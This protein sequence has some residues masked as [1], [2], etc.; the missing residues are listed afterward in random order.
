[1][2]LIA[3]EIA[4]RVAQ[5]IDLA[6]LFEPIGSPVRPSPLISHTYAMARHTLAPSLV[7]TGG[8]FETGASEARARVLA[9]LLH[10]GRMNAPKYDISD[11]S[12]FYLYPPLYYAAL[13]VCTSTT[14]S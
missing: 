6:T 8:D 12:R 1:M 5:N 9:A 2:A 14:G 13:H 3:R 10:G 11:V 7:C 4:E